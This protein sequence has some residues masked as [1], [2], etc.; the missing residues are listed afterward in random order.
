MRALFS[1]MTVESS[2]NSDH[3]VIGSSEG[4]EVDGQDHIFT[5]YSP[6]Y[7]PPPRS[8][9]RIGETDCRNSAERTGAA[10]HKLQSLY[11]SRRI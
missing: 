10:R 3:E 6:L 2:E 11:Q 5:P 9:A 4:A 1:A 7:L 8:S